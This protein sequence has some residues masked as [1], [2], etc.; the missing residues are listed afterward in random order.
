[1]DGFSATFTKRELCYLSDSLSSMT[2]GPEQ[3]DRPYPDLLLKIMGALLEAEAVREP[4]M[5]LVMPE[6]WMVREVAKTTVIVG[7]MG[8]EPVGYNLLIKAAKALEHLSAQGTLQ[9]AAMLVPD[10]DCVEPDNG[11][12]MREWK[13]NAHAGDND[14]CADTASSG[15]KDGASTQVPPG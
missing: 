1:M 13:E 7:G 4:I 14:T 3:G 6:W 9:D 5:S 15:A 10:G 11:A 8:G 12:R 2:Q